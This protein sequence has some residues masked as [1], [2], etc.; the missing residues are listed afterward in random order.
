MLLTFLP[1]QNL[2]VTG[3]HKVKGMRP[4]GRKELPAEAGTL[5]GRGGDR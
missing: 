2:W 1:R 3:V 4:E 5:A